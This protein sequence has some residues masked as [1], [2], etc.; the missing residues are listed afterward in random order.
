MKKCS[1]IIAAVMLGCCGLRAQADGD[2]SFVPANPPQMQRLTNFD[3]PAWRA[4]GHFLRGVNLGN[5]L[6]VPPGQSWRVTASAGDF[7]LMRAQGFDHVRVPV[8]WHHYAGPAPDFALSP[9]IFS[10]VDFVVTNALDA[11]LSVIINIHHFDELDQNPAA[12]TAEFLKI[13]GQIAAHYAK[14]P[15]RLAFE[16]DN[17]PHANATTAVMNPI[18]ARAIAE[19][20]ATN[21]HRTIFV[22]P[23]GWGSI[24]ELKHLVLPPDDN[25][26]VSAHCYDPFYFTHQG[27]TW[28]GPDPKVTGIQFPGP[29]KKPLVPDPSLKLHPWVLDWIH[30]YNTLPADKNPCSPLAFEG[31]LKYCRAWSDYYGRPVHIGEFGCFTTADPASR[32]RFYGAFRRAAEQERLGWAIWD[33]NAGFRYW[34]RQNHRPMPGLREALFGK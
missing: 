24:G 9:E 3:S 22:E 18:D 25:V 20:R 32:A 23:G 5:Y 21:P 4:A 33:W 34:D 16:L 29:P 14:F 30:R 6:E 28:A 1:T 11:G 26:I 12:A 27:A 31:K 13:W 2:D 19:I 7:A 8:G 10:R 17:E 15:Q